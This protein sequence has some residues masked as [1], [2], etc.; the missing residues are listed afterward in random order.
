VREDG[1]SGRERAFNR[2]TG[3]VLGLALGIIGGS[4]LLNVAGTSPPLVVHLGLAF[5]DRERAEE[6][7]A[8]QDAGAAPASLVRLARSPAPAPAPLP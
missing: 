1:N 3:A 4:L 2:H 6:R 5:T 8:A 7:G